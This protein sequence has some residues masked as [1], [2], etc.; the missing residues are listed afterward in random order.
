MKTCE[1]TLQDLVPIAVVFVVVT[2]CPG[3]EPGN[4]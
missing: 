4:A 2:I 1:F 3:E